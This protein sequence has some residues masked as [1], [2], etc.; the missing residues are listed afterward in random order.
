MSRDHPSGNRAARRAFSAI[1]AMNAAPSFPDGA[2]LVSRNDATLCQHV[3]CCQSATACGDTVA[4]TWQGMNN[5]ILQQADSLNGISQF[6][7]GLR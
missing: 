1:S 7:D 3:E 4:V 5:Q 6:T 2:S